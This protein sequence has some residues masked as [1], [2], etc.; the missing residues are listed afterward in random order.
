M[1]IETGTEKAFD[2]IQHQFMKKTVRKLGLQGKF[3]SFIKNTYRKPPV[4]FMCS[5]EE[6]TP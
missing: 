2:K 1:I 3:L 5:G 6:L 4:D